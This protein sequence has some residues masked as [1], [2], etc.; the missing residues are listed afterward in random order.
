MIPTPIAFDLEWYATGP[1]SPLEPAGDRASIDSGYEQVGVVHGSIE[2]LG[3]P[4][5]ELA[6]VPAHRWHR[7]TS[8]A[9]AFAPL[10]LADVRAHRGVR[11]PFAFPDGTVSD[12]VLTPEGWARR[13]VRRP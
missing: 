6:E 1:P 9:T 10:A 11:A 8:G 7:W 13:A 4:K 2:I 3:E 12:L 5:V